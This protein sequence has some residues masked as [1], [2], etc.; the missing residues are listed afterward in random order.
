MS[1][2]YKLL[3]EQQRYDDL[4]S[5]IFL[6]SN[7]EKIESGLNYSSVT[8]YLFNTFYFFLYKIMEVNT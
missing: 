3:L 5:S 6:G 7:N 4:D 1:S 8:Q 2:T